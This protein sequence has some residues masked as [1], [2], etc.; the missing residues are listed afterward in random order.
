MPG[1]SVPRQFWLSSGRSARKGAADAVSDA[2]RFLR[3]GERVSSSSILLVD[4]V[5]CKQHRTVVL[6]PEVDDGATVSIAAD[7]T[8]KSQVLTLSL[9]EDVRATAISDDNDMS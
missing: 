9:P 3:D 8:V 2:G 7:L 4:F 5:H 6:R 1:R